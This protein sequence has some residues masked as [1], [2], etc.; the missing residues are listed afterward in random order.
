MKVVL[1]QVTA[2]GSGGSSFQAE[3]AERLVK[4]PEAAAAGARWGKGVGRCTEVDRSRP[5][6]RLWR[7]LFEISGKPL[8]GF[9]ARKSQFFTVLKAIWL[10]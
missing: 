1:K 5:S 9:K 10:A 6:L 3:E 4:A 2:V 8:E 7:I